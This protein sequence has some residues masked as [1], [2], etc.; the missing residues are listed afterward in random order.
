M[1]YKSDKDKLIKAFTLEG[2]K[3]SLD[4]QI[5]SYNE[6]PPKLQMTRSFTRKDGTVDY[7]KGGR[8]SLK[9]VLFLKDAI[10]E[11]IKAMKEESK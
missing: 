2:D 7:G 11:I 4:F 1:A 3:G 9:E 6:Q 8:L 5:F 10:D